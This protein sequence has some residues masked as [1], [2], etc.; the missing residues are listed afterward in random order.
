MG[1]NI[2][3]DLFLRY[4]TDLIKLGDLSQKSQAIPT[5]LPTVLLTKPE[6]LKILNENSREVELILSTAGGEHK[7]EFINQARSIYLQKTELSEKMK[8]LAYALG[9][10]PEA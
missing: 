10:I 4:G 2:T 6:T 3:L 9:I 7:Q 1:K 8:E 5:L